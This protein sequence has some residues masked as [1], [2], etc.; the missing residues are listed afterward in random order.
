[1]KKILFLI[2]V[3]F[4]FNAEVVGCSYT[5][6]SFCSTL[7]TFSENLITYGKIIAVDTDGIYFEIIDVLRG[8]ENRNIIRIWDG[9]DFECNGTWSMAASELGQTDE[10][11]VLILPRIMEKQSDWDVIG[12]YRRP[13]FFG[14]TPTLK[15][16]NGIVYGLITGSY[17]YPYVEQNV[18]YENFKNSLE[19][20]QN[21]S[22]VVLGT[23][24]FESKE[25]FKVLTLPNNTFKI[26][27]N[28]S[29]ASHITIFN[30]FGLRVK[31]EAIIEKEI[32]VDLS[33]YSSGIYFINLTYENNNLKIIKVLKK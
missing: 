18:N 19:T 32:E 11:L 27:T 24:N 13:I 28:I 14:Y 22:S 31:S 12:D 20:T 26:S 6:A 9:V 3:N 2:L 30:V 33:N 17:S 1:M 8:S 16:E 23:E 10:T 21:C 4:V 25:I 29:K 5:P 7:D 15:V